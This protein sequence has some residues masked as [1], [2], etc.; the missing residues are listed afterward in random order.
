[1]GRKALKKQRAY[2]VYCRKQVLDGLIN[3]ADGLWRRADSSKQMDQSMIAGYRIG[4]SKKRT[5]VRVEVE[6]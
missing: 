1:M 6:G 3:H 2:Q 4:A 5:K